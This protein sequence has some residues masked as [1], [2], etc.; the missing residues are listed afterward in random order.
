MTDAPAS[1][2]LIL[3][4][5]TVD[6]IQLCD[7]L[8]SLSPVRRWQLRPRLSIHVLSIKTRDRRNCPRTPCNENFACGGL[9]RQNESRLLRGRPHMIPSIVEKLPTFT[10][11]CHGRGVLLNSLQANIARST[12]RGRVGRDTPPDQCCRRCPCESLPPYPKPCNSTA[13]SQRTPRHVV[14]TK[15]PANKTSLTKNNWRKQC[16]IPT[17]ARKSFATSLHPTDRL[18]IAVYHF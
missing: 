13:A 11:C 7:R 5:S 12:R 17:I 16:P 4:W 8:L 14:A 6:I 1:A 15:P 10:Q 18:R 2:S 9:T 3:Y